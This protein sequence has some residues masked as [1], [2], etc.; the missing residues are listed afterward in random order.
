MERDAPKPSTLDYPAAY[1]RQLVEIGAGGGANGAAT[2]RPTGK[3][4][5]ALR[6]NGLLQDLPPAPTRIHASLVIDNLFGH[7]A[8]ESARR[9]LTDSGTPPDEAGT[10]VALAMEEVTASR[11]RS[12]IRDSRSTVMDRQRRENGGANAPEKDLTKRARAVRRGPS[13]APYLQPEDPA[14]HEAPYRG[15][16]MGW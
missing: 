9:W 11:G 8:G 6:D 13:F 4:L 1:E 12:R 16:G 2:E 10:A 14:P 7:P 5:E 15:P 3:Q